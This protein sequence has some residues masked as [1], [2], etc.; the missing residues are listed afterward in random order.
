M[1]DAQTGRPEPHHADGHH[2]AGPAGPG[3]RE[4][5]EEVLRAL[6]ADPGAQLREDQ[7]TAIEALVAQRRRALVVNARVGALRCASPMALLRWAPRAAG[8][9]VIVALPL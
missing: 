9:T 2:H 4:R 3:L 8:L 7:W 1:S 5:A 6:V